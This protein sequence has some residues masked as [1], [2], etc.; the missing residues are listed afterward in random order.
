MDFGSEDGSRHQQEA[1]PYSQG[2][3]RSCSLSCWEAWTLDSDKP[4]TGLF[5]HDHVHMTEPSGALVF[6]SVQWG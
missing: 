5:I 1:S 3:C 2:M 6:S 4:G